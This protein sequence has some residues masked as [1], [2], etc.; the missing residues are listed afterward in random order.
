MVIAVTLVVG[1]LVVGCGCSHD[2][3]MVRLLLVDV[4]VLAVCSHWRGRIDS[5]CLVLLALVC[6]V[7]SCRLFSVALWLA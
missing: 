6:W 5:C 3:G 4:V 1:V 2:D 7:L